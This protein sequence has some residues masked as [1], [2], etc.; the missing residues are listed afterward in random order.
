MAAFYNLK[1]KSGGTGEFRCTM[2]SKTN[3]TY[4]PSDRRNIERFLSDSQ[5]N[6][7]EQTRIIEKNRKK[8]ASTSKKSSGS[9]TPKTKPKV[10]TSKSIPTVG[11]IVAFDAPPIN[12]DNVGH[13]MLAAMG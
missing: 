1:S 11:S 3:E 13:R 12:E 2:I 9:S 10:Y 7:D 5:V 8:F 4:I 6:V